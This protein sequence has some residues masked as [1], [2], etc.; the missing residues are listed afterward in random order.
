[1]DNKIEEKKE[2]DQ[3]SKPTTSNIRRHPMKGEPDYDEFMRE[4]F[5]SAGSNMLRDDEI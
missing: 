4:L 3:N 1:M 2:L 5:R